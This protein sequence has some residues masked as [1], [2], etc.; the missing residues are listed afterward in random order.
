MAHTGLARGLLIP[1]AKLRP[2]RITNRS[3]NSPSRPL[4][5]ACEGARAGPPDHWT[6]LRIHQSEYACWRGVTCGGRGWRR[7]E[8]AGCGDRSRSSALGVMRA[9]DQATR[10]KNAPIESRHGP[11]CATIPRK[12]MARL[13]RTGQSVEDERFLSHRMWG[14]GG[15]AT[16]AADGGYRIES[17]L[18]TCAARAQTPMVWRRRSVA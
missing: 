4:R 13:A 17:E 3:W 9:R 7:G 6:C 12:L 11:S 2:G 18:R 14:R 10:S 8:T 1:V 15:G 5:A 16:R